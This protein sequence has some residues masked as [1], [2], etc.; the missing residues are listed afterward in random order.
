ME[1]FET[2]VSVATDMIEEMVESSGSLDDLIVELML[3]IHEGG[4]GACI[5]D[6]AA[7]LDFKKVIDKENEVSSK[8]AVLLLFQQIMTGGILRPY[9]QHF[10]TPSGCNRVTWQNVDEKFHPHIFRS[11]FRYE[12]E[13]LPILIKSLEIPEEVSFD[14]YNTTDIEAILLMLRR[15]SS[16][17]R[18]SDVT[19][20]FDRLPQFLS[21]IFNGMC[22]FI[23]EKIKDHIRR[24]N[25]GFLM[26]RQKL[27]IWAKAFKEK[28][29]PLEN[30]MGNGDGTHIPV[31][32]P[33]E[34]QRSWYCGHHK[35]HC[36]KI[37]GILFPS[38][39]MIGWGPFDG[40]THDSAA[41][42]MI[43]MDELLLQYFTRPDGRPRPVFWDPAYRL[44]GA[45]I[46]QYR[47]RRNITPEELEWNRRMCAVRISVE[48]GFAKIKNLFRM[49]NHKKNL[50]ALMSPVAVYF[51]VG[52]HLTNIHSCLYGSEV[53][54]YFGVPPDKLEDYLA[55]FIEKIDS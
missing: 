7:L 38:G 17:V 48:W 32:R 18:Y 47:R 42:D 15:L 29:C 41:C 30:I 43:G 24:I 19:M 36:F 22:K 4:S 31:C 11:L 50:K 14:G 52:L 35:T 54:S 45:M 44:G 27:E 34:G 33:S 53:A 12:R 16:C 21:Q 13:D 1:E 37:Q 5:E 2:A 51:F 49:L 3:E 26:D 28:G 25:H 39:T 8:Q 20:E 10:T 40:P 55:E 9:Q 6:L 46:T 23:F